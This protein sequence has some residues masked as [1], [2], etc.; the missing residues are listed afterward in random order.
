MKNSTILN[1][2]REK[3]HNIYLQIE[4]ARSKKLEN[5]ASSYK[6]FSKISIQRITN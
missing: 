2:C 6:L 3:K 4:E 5:Q 1:E